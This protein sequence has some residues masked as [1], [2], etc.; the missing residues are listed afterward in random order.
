[1]NETLTNATVEVLGQLH[2][3]AQPGF[4]I[5][6]F[7]MLAIVVTAVWLVRLQRDAVRGVKELDAMVK[8]AERARLES[9]E[10]REHEQ[11]LLMNQ[12]ET[13]LK[14][15]DEFQLHI[16]L[17]NEKQDTFQRSMRD[18]LNGGLKEIKEKL[19]DVSVKEILAKIPALFRA[20]LETEL[21]SSSH[22][23]V[24]SIARQ[25]REVPDELI[26]VD[27]IER[28]AEKTSDV[29]VQKLQERWDGSY[30]FSDDLVVEQLAQ[31]LALHL[32]RRW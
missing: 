6:S 14:V 11:A 1:M 23:T 21:T 24:Q 22:R 3:A 17:L 8:A 30:P 5:Q 16:Q 26:D 4:I 29:L 28:V 25:L 9:R 32:S 12:L 13:V 27:A 19:Y 7:A 2:T 20:D 15:N 31:Q 18:S 10:N